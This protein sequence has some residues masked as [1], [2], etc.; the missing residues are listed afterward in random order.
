MVKKHSYISHKIF[1][2]ERNLSFE[3]KRIKGGDRRQQN[4][5]RVRECS[6]T[7]KVE[8]GSIRSEAE[9]KGRIKILRKRK[10]SIEIEA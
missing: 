2:L 3:N 7:E 5:K 8:G 1:F 10:F 9:V 4:W 6:V